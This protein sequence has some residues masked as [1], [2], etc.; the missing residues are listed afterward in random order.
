MK[1]ILLL[2]PSKTIIARE[3][4]EKFANEVRKH[5]GSDFSLEFSGIS[6]LF[7]ELSQDKIAIYDTKKK[8]DLRDFDLVV[9]RHIG[10]MTAEAHAIAAYCDF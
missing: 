3:K 9:M 5:L 2:T 6:D 1:K 8:F 7:F 4:A 10:G